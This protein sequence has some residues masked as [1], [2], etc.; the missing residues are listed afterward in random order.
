LATKNLTAGA[1]AAL[2]YDPQGPSLQVLWDRKV[3]GFGVRITPSGKRIYVLSFRTHGRSRLMHLG[4]VDDFNNVTQA[5]DAASEH[6]RRL[7]RDKVDP[8]A[9]RRREKAAGTLKLMFEQWLAHVAKKCSMRT[10]S[11]YRTYVESYLVPEIGTHRPVDLT[12]G[13]ARRLH[14][15][16]TGK[17]GT[18]TANRVVQALR[19]AYNWA[20][21]GDSDTLPENFVNPTVGLQWN[22]EKVRKEFVRPTELPALVREIQAEPNPLNKAYLWL[23]LLTGGRGCELISLKWE[24]VSLET[25]EL[26][27]KDTKNHEDFRLKLAGAAVDVL[28]EIPRTQSQYVFP[29][30]RSDGGPHMTRPR[31][32][33]YGALKRAGI[34]RRVTLHDTRRSTGVLLSSRGFTA[35]QIARQLNHKSNVTAK[36]YVQIADEIQQEMANT[37]GSATAGVPDAANK[38][39][40]LR[41]PGTR[42]RRSGAQAQALGARR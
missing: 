4:R 12:R 37:L 10:Y 14:T 20:T 3:A 38:A 5:R 18:V 34:E 27:F 24:E 8:L 7:R 29:S 41:A 23:T 1:I 15:K 42:A 13:E 21:E 19:N 2:K 17:H 22:R 40:P 25:G 11:D 30:Q 35:E 36:I 39:T 33:W 32:A 31:K 16:L 26:V 9:E 28:R 6:L